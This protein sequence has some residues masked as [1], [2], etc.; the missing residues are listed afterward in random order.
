VVSLLL[1]AAVQAPSRAEFT[2][3]GIKFVGFTA[4]D[5]H[6]LLFMPPAIAALLP[7][8]GRVFTSSAFPAFLNPRSSALCA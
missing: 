1:A 3:F 2:R 8:N 6:K 4:K 7:E 5:G